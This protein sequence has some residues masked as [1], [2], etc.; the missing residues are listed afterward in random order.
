MGVGFE[1][2]SNVMIVPL[3]H[4]LSFLNNL[5]QALQLHTQVLN[6]TEQ[7]RQRQGCGMVLKFSLSYQLS[8]LGL[9]QDYVS[10]KRVRH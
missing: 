3:L 7:E 10:T 2:S 8:Q 9:R 6:R 1:E 4:N 5:T